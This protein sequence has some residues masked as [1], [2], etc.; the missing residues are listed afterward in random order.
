MTQLLDDCK[1]DLASLRDD[2]DRLIK[3][4]QDASQAETIE[5]FQEGVGCADE[6]NIVLGADLFDLRRKATNGNDIAEAPKKE[7][8]KV[9]LPKEGVEP[10]KEE[11]KEEAK[12]EV[13]VEPP[14]EEVKI[15]EE[16][17]DAP[18]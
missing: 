13:K 16:I 5:E 11:P 10:I 14:K 8:V 1:K 9:E 3:C 15:A 2:A 17:K 18:V 6:M 12:A 7:E 4:L